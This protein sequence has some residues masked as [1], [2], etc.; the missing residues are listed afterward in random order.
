MPIGG[1]AQ[2]QHRSGE[3]RLLL[4]LSEAT[5][6]RGLGDDDSMVICTGNCATDV[7]PSARH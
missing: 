7:S 1:E 3:A 4:A 5:S 2:D 6:N